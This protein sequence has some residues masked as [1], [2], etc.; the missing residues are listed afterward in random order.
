MIVK[1]TLL[2]LVGLLCKFSVWSNVLIVSIASLVTDV[3]LIITVLLTLF[4]EVPVL[5]IVYP[6]F[7]NAFL[8]LEKA[9]ESPHPL[10]NSI[11]I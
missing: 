11:F 5:D 9:D 2:V 6:S 10:S 4:S 1:S 7:S 3:L 8:A